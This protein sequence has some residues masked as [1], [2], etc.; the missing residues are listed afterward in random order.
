[1]AKIRVYDLA[2]EMGVD[3]K[4]ILAELEKAGI[5][6]KSHSSNLEEDQAKTVRDRM[7]R[8]T[9]REKIKAKP[10]VVMMSLK[11]A[12]K[13][14]DVRPVAVPS[15]DDMPVAPPPAK[16]VDRAE[17]AAKVVAKPGRP[18]PTIMTVTHPHDELAAPPAVEEHPAEGQQ[19][20]TMAAPEDVKLPQAIVPGSE[21]EAPAPEGRAAAQ[22]EPPAT[23]QETVPEQAEAPAA[24]EE[25]K[26]ERHKPEIIKI[27]PTLHEPVLPV[28]VEE[29][30]EEAETTA[31]AA[32]AKEGQAAKPQQQLQKKPQH[33][34]PKPARPEIEALDGVDRI[35][36]IPSKLI[37]RLQ[38]VVKK[39]APS[40][41]EV[42]E[43]AKKDG[44]KWQDFK[45]VGKKKG[46][47]GKLFQKVEKVEEPG[48]VARK[49]AIKVTEGLTVKDFAEKLG[50]KSGDVIKK[51]F[52]MGIMANINQAVDP[53]AAVLIAD[54][55]GIKLDVTPITDEEA[56]VE[57]EMDRQE[58]LRP[59]PPVVTIM[60][61]VDHGKTSLL[62]A[63]RKT[64]VTGGEAGGI[65][66]HIGAYMVRLKDKDVVF[67]D[68]PGHEAFTAMRARG[69]QVTDIVVLVV[70]AEDG[71]RPQTIEAI[72]HSKAAKVPIIVAINKI[73]KPEAD[74]DKVKRELADHGLVPEEWG[75]DTIFVPVSAKKQIGLEQLLEMILLQA[76]VMELKANP[77]KP[78]RG[79]I[80]EAKLDKGRGPVATVLVS[81]G[82]IRPGDVFVT[83]SHSGRIRMLLND[84]GK[85]EKEAGP[86]M[87]VE[88]I[89]LSGVPQAGDSFVVM[90]DEKKARQVAQ[91]RMQK[92]REAELALNKRVTLDDLFSQIQQGAVKEL[93][94][95]IK[96]DVQGSAEAVAESLLKLST[97]AVKLKVIHASVGAITESDIM[98]ASASNAII[99]GFNIRPEPKASALAESEGVDVRLY[100]IIYNAIDEVRAAMEGLLEPTFKE[101]VLGRAEVRQTFSVPKVG[102]I[103]G[104]YVLDGQIT[105]SCAGVRV[106]RDN[107]VVFQ[108]KLG[109]LKRFKDDVKEAL[110]G[111]ECG[112]G[113][114]NFNDIKVG[115]I[116]E[117][118]DI[119]KFAG[120]L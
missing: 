112:I 7:T 116:I 65:T 120:K 16:K 90:E 115:D 26:P 22:P 57:E 49:R 85:K 12:G 14:K 73:D 79:T 108:G 98:L 96:A 118:Y 80:I 111:Y 53:D 104:T 23:P 39:K 41:A 19:E 13:A 101:K 45:T 54:S 70:A 6:G 67:L 52:E 47:K 64:N 69:A 93:N 21:Q 40:P 105:R 33:K 117:A 56:F 88:V 62:D 74:P 31:P 95:I 3:N 8:K 91:S 76:D 32:A 9:L 34:G 5:T 83:G 109:S 51:L 50:Q 18:R 58:D 60:G 87:P 92:L 48:T 72:N 71:A 10:E 119:E 75:G 37:N 38:P 59:R 106:L 43:Q 11:P 97:D 102:V 81:S 1:M 107:V 61:H 24:P 99:I 114:E 82:T 25:P 68:T 2:R 15:E 36:T 77:N 4:V 20:P 100:N 46:Q 94:I 30:A 29:S 44:R 42:A 78:G 63:I 84:K 110:A 35:P 55:Y 89:G 66:Q 27:E 113:V 103:A 28:I 17:K 86:A